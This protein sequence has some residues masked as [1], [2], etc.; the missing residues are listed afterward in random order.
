MSDPD[1]A[2]V[3]SAPGESSDLTAIFPD[4][5]RGTT[6][7]LTFLGKQPSCEHHYPGWPHEPCWKLETV[8]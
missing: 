6:Y 1:K 3:D 2:T 7:R 8:A 4:G 5:T